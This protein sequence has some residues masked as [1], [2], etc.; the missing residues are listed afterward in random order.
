MIDTSAAAGLGTAATLWTS[1]GL[2]ADPRAGIYRDLY[3]DPC[4]PALR[5][6]DRAAPCPVQL[7]RPRPPALGGVLPERVARLGARPIVYVSLGAPHGSQ[8]RDIACALTTPC[9][10]RSVAPWRMM[11]SMTSR[12][13]LWSFCSQDSILS[14]GSRGSILSIGSVGSVLSIG[15]IGSACSVLSI[16]SFASVA[17]ILSSLADR[18][19]MSHHSR[20]AVLAADA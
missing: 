5:L 8:D 3:L 15:S 14:I 4:P 11:F 7:L 9:G 10:G 2:A 16:G 17:S 18:S 20:R 6:G 12:G 13:S 19:L 1:A